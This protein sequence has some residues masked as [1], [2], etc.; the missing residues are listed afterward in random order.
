[1]QVRTR[2]RVNPITPGSY[3]YVEDCGARNVTIRMGKFLYNSSHVFFGISSNFSLIIC[4]GKNYDL[5][6]TEGAARNRGSF[7]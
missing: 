6:L 3:V 2:H 5:I 1:M 4:S 7:E